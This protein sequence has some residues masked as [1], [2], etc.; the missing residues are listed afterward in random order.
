MTYYGNENEHG[1]LKN[2]REINYT[3]VYTPKFK[4]GHYVTPKSKDEMTIL[5]N[6]LNH[7]SNISLPSTFLKKQET[8][9]FDTYSQK[10][11]LCNVSAKYVP[12]PKKLYFCCSDKHPVDDNRFKKF[13]TYYFYTEKYCNFCKENI[14]ASNYILLFNPKESVHFHLFSLPKEDFEYIKLYNSR[15]NQRESKTFDEDTKIKDIESGF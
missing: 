3:S 14:S 10:V 15:M 4:Q 2:L 13:K 5:I 11:N 6:S 8:F 12:V 7:H 9:L 1:F